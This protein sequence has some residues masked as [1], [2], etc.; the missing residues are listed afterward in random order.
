KM[1]AMDT[2]PN[3]H[4]GRNW[5]SGRGCFDN[6]P[7]RFGSGERPQ[8]RAVGAVRRSENLGEFQTWKT[9]AIRA[10][11]QSRNF[12]RKVFRSRSFWRFKRATLAPKGVHQKSHLSE[13]HGSGN[14][15]YEALRRVPT[16][17][18]RDEEIPGLLHNV[19]DCRT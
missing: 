10:Y 4:A 3:G 7:T 9:H 6:R 1:G 12:S 18:N 5:A 19:H 17:S 11:F 8:G 2:A 15:L 13:G 14:F 16:S